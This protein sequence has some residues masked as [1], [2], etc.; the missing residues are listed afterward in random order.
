MKAKIMYPIRYISNVIFT[1]CSIVSY[2]RLV[3]VMIIC[4]E[5]ET[6]SF[7]E[8]FVLANYGPV[9]LFSAAYLKAHPNTP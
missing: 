8:V 1:T 2:V 3:L 6:I 4:L 5:S 7:D 9:I